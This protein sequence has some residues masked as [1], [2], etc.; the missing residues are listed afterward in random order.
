[1]P[2][3][4]GRADQCSGLTRRDSLLLDEVCPPSTVFAACNEI[5]SAKHI[6]VFPFGVHAVPSAHLE[7]Q[8][9]HLRGRLGG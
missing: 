5:T 1:V 4:G 3:R 8:L 2:P 9:G 6:A 7:A